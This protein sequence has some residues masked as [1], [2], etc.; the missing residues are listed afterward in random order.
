MGEHGL[1]Q[2]THRLGCP[3]PAH[4]VDAPETR[5]VLKHRPDGFALPVFAEVLERFE[6]FFS[7]L[8]SHGV[9]S[10]MAIVRGQLSPMMAV[11]K[12]VNR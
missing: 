11:Q 12:R 5:L 1:A 2:G 4:I 3:A 8:L 10:W 6:E 9:I 7:L